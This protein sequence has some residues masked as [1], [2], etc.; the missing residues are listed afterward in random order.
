MWSTY[1]TPLTDMLTSDGC[2]ISGGV[3]S[4][5]DTKATESANSLA[6]GSDRP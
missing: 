2:A 4:I 1:Q 5:F 6:A 3:E